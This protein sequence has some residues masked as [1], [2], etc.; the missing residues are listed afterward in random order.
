M[1]PSICPFTVLVNS[2]D[3]FD[4]CWD[5]FF[6]LFAR[7]WPE[8]LSRIVLNTE[9]KLYLHQPLD[10]EC[11]QVQKGSERRLTWSECLLA[12]LSRLDTSLVL[13]MQE[14]YF[15][16]RPVLDDKIRKAATAMLADPDI[17]HVALTSFGSE[18]PYLPFKQDLMLIRPHARYRISTQAAL[19]RVDTLKSYLVPSESGWMFEIYGTWRA[20]RRREQFC[21]AS[22][23]A[24]SGGPAM[25]YLHTGII[26]GKWLPDIASVFERNGITVD[27]SRRGFYI[28]KTPFLRKLETA[29]RLVGRPGY[30]LRQ[31]LLR[32]TGM[33]I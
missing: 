15:I 2:S 1:T 8:Y 16:Q 9:N 5:P 26:K 21:C 29:R 30:L 7:Y 33:C 6:V 23:D 18:G 14:D 11:T 32:M 22:F 3:S 17:K 19:W 4:D 13:Y 12:A 10:I 20:R 24:A 28:S 25:E 27:Y 31:F